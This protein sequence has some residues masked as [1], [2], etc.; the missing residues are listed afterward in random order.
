MKPRLKLEHLPW[1]LFLVFVGIGWSMK[2]N[3]DP[4][5]WLNLYSLMVFS[6]LAFAV[7]W[8]IER[9][10][11]NEALRLLDPDIRRHFR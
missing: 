3:P 7:L 4:E 11:K 1:L 10:K 6:N 2:G 9:E 8:L 5:E